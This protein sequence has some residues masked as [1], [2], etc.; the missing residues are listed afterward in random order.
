MRTTR[1]HLAFGTFTATVGM[2]CALLMAA[3]ASATTVQP[4]TFNSSFDG[5]DAVGA[6]AFGSSINKVDVDESNGLVYVGTGGGYVY[7]LD[8][9]GV[10]EPFQALAG[11]TVI[12]QE[13]DFN[14]D[15]EVDNSGTETQG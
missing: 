15:L 12:E 1:K 8:E 10:S 14:G 4:H 5:S 7:K 9:T 13:V 11:R 6:P 2:L 3:T